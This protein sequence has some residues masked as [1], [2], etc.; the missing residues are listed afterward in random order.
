MP[1]SGS[2]FILVL[3]L[4]CPAQGRAQ[5]S[6]DSGARA[7]ALGGAGTALSHEAT[8]Y[9]NPAVWA[10]F[11]GRAVSFF[12]SEAFGLSALRLGAVAYVA[13]TRLGAIALGARTF[14]FEDFR[15]VHLQGGF[16]RGFRLGT[17]RRFLG[18]VSLRYHHVAIPNYGRAGT[19]A[20]GVG[21]L[22]ALWPS[23][24]VG[25]HAANIQGP[26]LAGQTLARS[27]ALGLA[28]TPMEQVL[29]VI[30]T[31]KDVRFPLS[32][33]AGIEVQPIEALL[34]RAGAATAPARI[35]AG[36]GLHLGKLQAAVAGERHEVLGWSPAVSFGLRW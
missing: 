31:Y 32:V 29:I 20:V 14:G 16:A 11:S 3:L 5:T 18:G 27:L 33:R 23:V 2:V 21:G 9:A 22:V 30:D 36:A 12:A 6:I 4:G 26:K 25:F 8:G 17:T 28:Y 24:Q 10:T 19:L 7:A 1:R 15:E 35:T 13:P 34:L